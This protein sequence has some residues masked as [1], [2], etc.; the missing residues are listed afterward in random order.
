[1]H[2]LVEARK[3]I[4]ATS[5]TLSV[6]EIMFLSLDAISHFTG[7]HV[8]ENIYYM[9]AAQLFGHPIKAILTKFH[10]RP[11]FVSKGGMKIREQTQHFNI[12]VQ[13]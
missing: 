12:K 11:D 5:T 4:S 2:T 10:N 1:V 7:L 9:S 6:T 13:K 3:N 8:L